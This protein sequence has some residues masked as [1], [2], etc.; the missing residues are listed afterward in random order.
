MSL[1]S[2]II[3][4]NSFAVSESNYDKV[5][6]LYQ[7]QSYTLKTFVGVR[8]AHVAYL[9]F[10]ENIGKRGSVLITTGRNE[11][12]VR[13]LELA[14]DLVQMG[15]S[16]IYVS[17]HR[18]QGA[19]DRLLED[20]FKGH[21][22]R[23][24]DYTRD[25]RRFTKLVRKEVGKRTK[26]FH[27]THSMG[28]AITMK[29]LQKYPSQKIFEK[30]AFV[31]PMFK[32]RLPLSESKILKNLKKTCRNEQNCN[33]YISG[34]S[35]V[36]PN[37]N[38]SSNIITS[39]EVRFNFFQWLF[40]QNTQNRLGSPTNRWLLEAIKATRKIRNRRKIR[41]I[42]TPFKVFIA[43]DD[44]VVDNSIQYEICSYTR[45]CRAQA[46]EGSQH[47]TLFERDSIRDQLIKSIDL[48]FR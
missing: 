20:K 32:I 46:L 11:S 34:G 35:S 18:G 37:P 47:N 43:E 22:K 16:P 7:N 6:S 40:E 24:F 15:F 29:F 10:G 38:F 2:I 42:T 25:F 1:F 23:F 48:F 28:G 4:L 27:L 26:I 12:E 5:Y 8:D 33:D 41:S 3:S 31:S 13:Y 19:S 17:A 14:Y 44:K 36:D 30:V 21:V 9:K 39:S 45:I